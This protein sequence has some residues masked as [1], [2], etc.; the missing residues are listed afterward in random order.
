MI[1]VAVLS[2]LKEITFSKFNNDIQSCAIW[3]NKNT[4]PDCISFGVGVKNDYW[5]WTLTLALLQ[6]GKKCASIYHPNNLSKNITS[7]FDAFIMDENAT[8]SVNTTIFDPLNLDIKHDETHADK[9]TLNLNSK[10]QRLILTSGTTGTPKIVSISA[11]NLRDRIKSLDQEF[12]TDYS[13]HTK[14]LNLIGIDTVGP[15]LISLLTWMRGGTVLFGEPDPN[16]VNKFNIPYFHSTIISASPAILRELVKNTVEV[17]PGKEHRQLRVGGSRLYTSLRDDAI[18]LIANRVQNTYGSTEL[19][20]IATCDAS[21]L[22][23]DPGAAGQVFRHVRV[24]IVDHNDMPVQNGETGRIRCKSPGMALAYENSVASDQFKNGW[25]YP[26][27]IGT[28]SSTGWLSISG[29]DSE[30]INLGGGKFSSV[31]L[32]SQLMNSCDLIDVCI[33]VIEQPENTELAVAVVTDDSVDL[34]NLRS[35]ISSLLPIKAGFHLLRVPHLPRN[36]MGKLPRHK[37]IEN[38][39]LILKSKTD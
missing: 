13:S 30:V 36:A 18:R 34:Q 16:S 29:R 35:S 22:D 10:A 39:K 6:L 27:D 7:H 19:G 5:H 20:M 12:K 11:V 31:D 8:N 38:I 37:I 2:G 15:F 33:V 25:F 1:N 14:L 9:L 21:V 32:E 3:I 28:L 26:G 24:E 23:Y 17:W 4:S